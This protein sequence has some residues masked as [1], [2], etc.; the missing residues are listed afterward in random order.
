MSVEF[1]GNDEKIKSELLTVNMGP[2][3]PAT[4]GVLR[5]EIKTDSEIVAEAIP[6]IGYLHRCME[7]HCENADY[8]AIVPFVDRMDYLAS[9]NMELGYAITIEK[10]ASI[11]VPRR[12]E[13]IRVLVSELQR[14][15]SHL[16]AFGTYG[17]DIGAFTP[18]LY[19]FD[20]REKIISF[21]E[22]IS[23]G[24]LLYN[25][26]SIGGVSRDVSNDL[27]VGLEKFC[28]GF[29]DQLKMYDTLLTQNKIFIERTANVGVMDKDYCYDYGI[30]GPVLRGAGVEWDLRKK[31]PY[32][33]YNEFNFE[34][35]VG[36]GLKGCVGDCWDRYYVR[37]VE[38]EQS[39]KIIK[40]ALVKLREEGGEFTTK[41]PRV[42]K[43]PVGEIYMRTECPKGEL[44]YHIISDGKKGPYRFKVKSPC[45]TNVSA[46]GEIAPGMMIADLVATIGSLDIVLGEVD[47]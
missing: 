21:F 33:I 2:Q 11:A 23:G 32:S 37:M 6:H 12:A 41:V 22:S 42:I 8:R 17:I 20:Q 24:R 13:V 34:V 26:I 3:H 28:A 27:I 18:F 45:F 38:M 30:T 35:A 19:A 36:K 47:R 10:L 1:I 40:Q 25:Y 44:G 5:V 16:V 46:L 7:K 31:K 9:M 39:V 15:A 4:H 43:V 14:I 29:E